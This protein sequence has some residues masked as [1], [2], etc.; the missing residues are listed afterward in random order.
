METE[1]NHSSMHDA[2]LIVHDLFKRDP[3]I[4]WIDFLVS[5][6]VGY[7]C[8]SI[9][10]TAPLFSWIQFVFL[11]AAV[12]SLYR[13]TLFMHEITHFREG[14][15]TSFKVAWNVLAG[16]PLVT[17][18]F[19]YEPHRDHHNA[20]Q[21][22]TKQ[23]GEYLP[24]A[25]GSIW[26]IL[27]FLAESF[28]LPL[29]FA[30]RFLVL[31]PL[32]FCS[33]KLRSWVLEHCSSFVIDMRYKR[34]LRAKDQTKYW[35]WMEIGLHLRVLAI[36]VLVFAGVN[37]WY[38]IPQLYLIAV[39]ILTLNAIRTLAAHR[40]VSRGERMTFEDQ[41]L[42]SV[43]I[44]GIPVITELFFPV[45]LRYHALHHCFPTMPYHNFKR[46]HQRLMKE[47]PANSIYRNCVYP[48]FFSVI[49]ELWCEVRSNR[50]QVAN[51]TVSTGQA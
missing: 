37:P 19:L 40:Y 1:T 47:L 10:L 23:D 9:Y 31:T 25:H 33:P 29:F 5:L 18:S 43:D 50:R 32:S 38:R 4:Y 35:I 34:V 3:K 20:R 27:S 12:I 16:I 42:D 14:E 15:M 7:T 39:C 22:G 44:V 2:R 49:Y 46:A 36:F 26:G 24:L 45:G 11:I 6:T 28:Y 8:A 51:S 13:V 48:S 21:Y 17:P 41:V 30:F